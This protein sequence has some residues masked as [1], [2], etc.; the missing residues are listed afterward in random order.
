MTKFW[1]L[2]S[3]LKSLIDGIKELMRM[4]KDREIEGAVDSKEKNIEKVIN[5]ESADRRSKFSGADGV[6]DITDEDEN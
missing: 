1:A 5:S 2:I 3:I 6:F 4:Q